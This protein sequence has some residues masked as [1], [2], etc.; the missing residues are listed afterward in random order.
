[1]YDPLELRRQTVK[2]VGHGQKMTRLMGFFLVLP[3]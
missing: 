3:P 2:I 1:M